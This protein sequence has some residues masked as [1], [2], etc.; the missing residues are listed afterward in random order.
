MHPNL[1]LQGTVFHFRRRVPKPIVMLLERNEIVH[2]LRTRC[3]RQ[4]ASRVRAVFLASERAFEAVSNSKP[5]L[6]PAQAYGIVSRWLRDSMDALESDRARGFGYIDAGRLG[7]VDPEIAALIGATQPWLAKFAADE[8]TEALRSNDVAKTEAMGINLAARNGVTVAPGSIDA[9]VLARLVM[10]GFLELSQDIGRRLNGVFPPLHM[11]ASEA[12]QSPPPASMAT[13]PTQF[14]LPSPRG[15]L[16]S[17][18]YKAHEQDMCGA[19]AHPARPWQKQTRLQNKK[20]ADLWTELLG[21]RPVDSYT[22][23]NAAAFKR[24]LEHLPT[25]HGKSANDTR[26]LPEIVQIISDTPRDKR[27]RTIVMK[28]VKRHMSAISGFFSWLLD[29]PEISKLNGVNIALNFKYG[30][31]NSEEDRQMW[32][33]PDLAKLFA[34]PIWTGCHS[35]LMRGKPGQI[36]IRDYQFWLPILALFH[37][38][39]QEEVAQLA[40]DDVA[41]EDGIAFIRVHDEDGNQLKNEQSV[42]RIP[43]H[44]FI[45]ELGFLDYVA[46]A[47]NDGLVHLWPGMS[48]S[49]PDG[50]YAYA[51]S[52]FFGRYCR[53]TGI[54]VEGRGFHSLRHTFRTFTEETDTKSIWISRLMGHKLTTLLGEGATYTK[55]KGRKVPLATLKEAVDAFDPGVDLSH[56]LLRNKE[57]SSLVS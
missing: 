34:T 11:S 19:R 48:R 2:S 54:F 16:F 14:L 9:K 31:T 52:K 24:A 50:K 26:T 38:M 27:P 17:A 56:L 3:P 15:I 36:L 12:S 1:R 40:V 39:R 44:R 23:D 55:T 4:A 22:R 10:R 53:N 32:E 8:W 49:G 7:I 47:K 20:T 42:R 25:N 28:T 45:I 33:A 5:A 41:N 37:G 13:P 29:R 6:P 51:Y 46:K 35:E 57:R 30:V 43:I 21:D 18:G